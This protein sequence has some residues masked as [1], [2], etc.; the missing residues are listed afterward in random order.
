VSPYANI[1]LGFSK[2]SNCYGS[3]L[4]VGMGPAANLS[5]NTFLLLAIQY[6]IALDINA[7]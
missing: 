4:P 7:E 3:F 6:R 2:Y 5:H 1:G